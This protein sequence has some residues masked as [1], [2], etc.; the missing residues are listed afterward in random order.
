MAGTASV[1]DC[2]RACPG[3]LRVSSFTWWVSALCLDR[4][5]IPLRLR[6]VKG[7]CVFSCN[8]PL[9]LW[10]NDRPS[11]VRATAVT[12][13][14]VVVEMTT[15]SYN[16]GAVCCVK[17]V[18]FICP[19][20]QDYVQQRSCSCCGKIRPLKLSVLHSVFH[21]L[22]GRQGVFHCLCG[23]HGVFHCL[24]GRHGVFHCLCGIHGVFHTL[25]V[26][27]CVPLSVW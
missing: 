15:A 8:L 5:F 9:R 25:C 2:G 3:E 14:L 24:C 6:V 27:Q 13:G 20:C 22:G 10:R 12:R 1:G 18:A 23:R 19:A 4:T 17:F 7:V 21:C 26:L 16:C 11:L